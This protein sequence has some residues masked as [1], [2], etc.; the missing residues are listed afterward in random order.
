ME[1]NIVAFMYDFDKTLS[2]R[3]MQEYGFIPE[4]GLSSGEFWDSC[5]DFGSSHG[6]DPILAYMWAMVR[7]SEGKMLL[8]RD[9]I[10][11]LGSSVELFPG[12]D[13]WFERVNSY[14]E[15]LGLLPE[16][17]I[18]SSGLKEIIEGT[19]IAKEFKMIYAGE[20]MYN[21]RNVPVWP[22]KTVNYTNK[23]QFLFRINKGVLDPCDHDTLNRYTP[24]DERRVPFKNMIYIGDGFTDVPSMKVVREYGGHSIAVYTSAHSDVANEMIRYGRADYMLP[25]DYTAGSELEKTVKLLTQLVA[26]SSEATAMHIEQ[27][28][29]AER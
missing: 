28:K 20:F 16:H 2:P 13:T 25:A 18:I 4:L 10:R 6:M 24:H 17:Y 3:D 7:E 21:D 19:S 9:K 22:A 11:S 26:L 14:A 15:S 12:V 27:L 1:K 29:R 23:T 8:T 5:N